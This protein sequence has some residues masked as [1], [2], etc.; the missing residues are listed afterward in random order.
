MGGEQ[1]TALPFEGGQI[2]LTLDYPFSEEQNT[3]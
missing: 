2:S 1:T 3:A